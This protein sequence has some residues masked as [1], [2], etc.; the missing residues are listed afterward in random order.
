MKLLYILP[1]DG[2][3][4]AEMER[5]T[6]VLREY[7]FD[8]T[9][10]DY[11]YC[12]N[13]VK[14]IESYYEDSLAAP[15]AM[16]ATIQAE[17]D[18]YDGVIL[19]CAGDPGLY[20]AREMVRI[21][22]IGPGE[23]AVHQACMMGNRFSVIAIADNCIPRHY[24]LIQR[25]GIRPDKVASVRAANV[26]VLE[27]AKDPTLA[28]R[29]VAEEARRA[30]QEDGADVIILGCM[31]LAFSLFDKELSEML[32]IPV[33]NPA[34]AALKQL[35]GMVSAGMHHSKMAYK[36]PPKYRHI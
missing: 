13:G 35:E 9:Q 10:V 16:N 4:E 11:V 30:M 14:S 26:P 19:G 5:R 3:T 32:G 34:I 23:N 36:I 25:A 12:Q 31:T 17:K 33:I 2:M 1:G 28:K 22:V 27:A 24:A 20:G 6:Q 18:G 29:R 15:T 8:G 7:A 21:P